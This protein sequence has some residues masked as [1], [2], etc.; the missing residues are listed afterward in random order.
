MKKI[1]FIVLLVAA[2]F[3]A[4][5]AL[6]ETTVKHYIPEGEFSVEIP[7]DILCVSRDADETNSF[8]QIGSYDYTTMHQYMLDNNMYLYGITTDHRAE[9]ALGMIDYTG[10]DFRETD[11]LTLQLIKNQ[12]KETYTAQGVSD[13]TADIYEGS[14]K[15]AMCIRYSIPSPE[16]DQYVEFYYITHGSKMVLIRFISFFDPISDT[17]EKMIR[18]IIETAEWEKKDYLAEPRGETE[19]G[20]YTDFETGLTFAVPSGWSE[21]K[22]VAAE[23]GKK[24]KYRIGT[25]NVWVLYEGGDLWD[26]VAE[27]SGSLIE[28]AGITRKDVGNNL[29]SREMIA[30]MLGC[31]ESEVSMKTVG[32]QEYYC[33]NSTASVTSGV[34][35]VDAQNI[36]YIC[37]RDAYMYWFQLSG[38]NIGKY[39]NDFNR[40]METIVY[41]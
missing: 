39:E 23:A 29:L 27:D 21:V 19:Q 1:I 4:G 20:I 13:V 3:A 38:M 7:I 14:E 26:L 10:D 15:T 30:K 9:F 33:M 31:S 34:L 36:V 25:D 6:A 16:L 37:V 8:Y 18:N 41:P 32:G 28:S 11:Q 5:C 40:F 24:V 35:S 12:L 2:L 22:F 17:Q